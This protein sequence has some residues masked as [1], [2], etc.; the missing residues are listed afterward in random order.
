M[1]LAA[2]AAEQAVPRRHLADGRCEA[3]ARRAMVWFI[4]PL[5]PYGQP[6]VRYFDVSRFGRGQVADYARRKGNDD[7]PGRTLAAWTG[8]RG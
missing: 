4:G 2:R 3:H 8:R 7:R 5:Q 6:Q 1:A